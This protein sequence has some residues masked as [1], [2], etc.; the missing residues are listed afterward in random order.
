MKVQTPGYKTI[1][2][3]SIN[4]NISLNLYANAMVYQPSFL[5]DFIFPI[6]R[7]LNKNLA[8]SLS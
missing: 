7:Q 5:V 6:F 1:C 4:E 8:S 2:A 3:H